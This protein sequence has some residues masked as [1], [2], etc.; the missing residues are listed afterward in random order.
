MKNCMIFVLMICFMNYVHGMS[1]AEAQEKKDI[2]EA[3]LCTGDFERPKAIRK[4]KLRCASGI[5]WNKVEGKIAQHVH[6]IDLFLA[7]TQHRALEILKRRATCYK[8]RNED[9]GLKFKQDLMCVDKVA[10]K[11]TKAYKLERFI[12]REAAIEIRKS[13]KCLAKIINALEFKPVEYAD[14]DRCK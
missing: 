11:A 1:H 5:E 13:R 14:D 12:Q 9:D 4:L 10:T 6:R 3:L 8:V 7:F 2:F